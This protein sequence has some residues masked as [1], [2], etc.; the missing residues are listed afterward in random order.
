MLTDVAPGAVLTPPQL[1]ESSLNCPCSIC[2]VPGAKLWLPPS[3][4][5]ASSNI[6]PVAEATG[7]T[8]GKTMEPVTPVIVAV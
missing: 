3:N 8:E 2:P 6:S 7:R 5:I 1:P 4:D